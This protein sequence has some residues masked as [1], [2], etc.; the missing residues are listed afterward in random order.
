MRYTHVRCREKYGKLVYEHFSR[1]LRQL[2]STPPSRQEFASIVYE[3]P[4]GTVASLHMLA[5]IDAY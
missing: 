4:Q 1:A 5:P 3:I 2:K